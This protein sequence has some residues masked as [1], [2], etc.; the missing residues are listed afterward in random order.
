MVKNLPWN[1]R[2]KMNLIVEDKEMEIFFLH[3]S[4]DYA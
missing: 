2:P 4:S 1:I 3:D